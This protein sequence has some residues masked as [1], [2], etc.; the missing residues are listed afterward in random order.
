MKNFK[1]LSILLAFIFLSCENQDSS[2]DS[3]SPQIYFRWTE[4]LNA[5]VCPTVRAL[6]YRDNNNV[7]P[8]NASSSVYYG[9]CLP[10]TYQGQYEFKDI[11]SSGSGIIINFTYVLESPPAGYARYY[12]KRLC[13]YASNVNRCISFATENNLVF[14]DEK[15]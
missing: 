5:A 15:L 4:D 8:I 10:G 2:I 7:V 1:I 12:S 11:A 13:G 6:N 3:R 14:I 9:S